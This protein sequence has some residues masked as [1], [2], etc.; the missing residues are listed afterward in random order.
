MKHHHITWDLYETSPDMVY[1]YLSSHDSYRAEECLKLCQEYGIA[2]AS[3]YLLERMGN[4]S[5]ALQLILQTLE[6]RMMSLKRTIRGMGID[7]FRQHTSRHFLNGKGN[8]EA[9]PEQAREGGRWRNESLLL[10]TYANATRNLAPSEHGSQLWFNVLDRLINAKGFLRLSKEQPEHSKVMAGVLSELLRLTMQRMVS[11]VP[12]TD[13]VRK[14]TSDHSGSQIGELREMVESLL[15]T[16]GFELNVF[17]SAVSVFRDDLY[18]MRKGQR[19]L[20]LEGLPVLAVMNVQLGKESPTSREDLARLSASRDTALTL[21]SSGNASIVSRGVSSSSQGDESGLATALSRLRSRRGGRQ[22]ES[23]SSRSAALSMMTETDQ[24]YMD[25]ETEPVVD[26]RREVG[27]LG[28]AEHRG[29]LMT[30]Q[31]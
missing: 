2:D 31:Y 26:G 24:M 7:V 3:A 27:M 16:Y 13:L 10:S 12:L 14:V 9:S 17:R 21:T 4:V 1:D 18:M 6:S 29:R 8:E 5:S 28:D 15:G 20:R 19:S 23:K 25:G 30:F 11:S 22:S